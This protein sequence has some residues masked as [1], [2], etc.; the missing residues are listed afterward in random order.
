MFTYIYIYIYIYTSGDLSL[1]A[2]E[3]SDQV[4]E[5]SGPKLTVSMCCLCIWSSTFS[6]D[7]RMRSSRGLCW[8]SWAALGAYV[9]DLGPSVGPV[10]AVLGRSWGSCWRSGAALGAYVGGLGPLLEPMLAVLGRSWGHVGGPWRPGAEKC[11]KP[12]REPGP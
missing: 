9:R 12:E 10:L 1:T 3:L 6:I 11:A 8:R 2:T 7:G 4:V 5:S